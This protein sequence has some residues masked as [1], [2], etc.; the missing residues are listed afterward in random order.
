M[1]HGHKD[2]LQQVLSPPC[3][4]TPRVY[5][6]V[7]TISPFH[8]QGSWG[9]SLKVAQGGKDQASTEPGPVVSKDKTL[10]HRTIVL[11]GFKSWENVAGSRGV[12]WPGAM[13]R[14]QEA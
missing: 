6:E 9:H 4:S 2:Q 8:R 3:M 5:E 7:T 12:V 14:G 10:P 11:L 1:E 13:A